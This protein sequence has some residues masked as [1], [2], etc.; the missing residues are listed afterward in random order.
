M[1]RL[2]FRRGEPIVR[3]T[4]TLCLIFVS[5]LAAMAT[6]DDPFLG[7]WKLNNYKSD[8]TGETFKLED[9]ANGRIRYSGGGQ[10]YWFTTDGVEHPGLAGRMVTV[11]KVDD[12]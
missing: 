8:F 5:G 2:K 9:A 1:A 4:H 11:N 12:H 7:K 3:R 6:G 10:S